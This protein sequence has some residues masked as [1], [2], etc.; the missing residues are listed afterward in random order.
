[1]FKE[2]RPNEKKQ[3]TNG[4]QNQGLSV[5]ESAKLCRLGSVNQEAM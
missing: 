1:M 2:Q 5:E 4:T 3:L